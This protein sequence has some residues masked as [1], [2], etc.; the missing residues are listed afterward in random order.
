[1]SALSKLLAITLLALFGQPFVQPLLAWNATGKASLPAC[2]RRNGNDHCIMSMAERLQL[3]G[4]DPQFQAPGEKCPYRQRTTALPI[5][6][7]TL[8]LLSARRFL[9]T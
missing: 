4:C 1:M 9:R 8:F 5:R 2:C 6:G 3:I 7:R